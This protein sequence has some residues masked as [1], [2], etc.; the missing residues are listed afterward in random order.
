MITIPKLE[1]AVKQANNYE[2]PIRTFA[3]DP[4]I[5]VLIGKSASGKSS[6]A[7]DICEK[8]NIQQIISCTSRPPRQNEVNGIDYNFLNI[9]DFNSNDFIACET[10]KNWK[11]GVRKTDVE[12]PRNSIIVLTPSGFREFKEQWGD[13]VV[14]IYL[15]SKTLDRVQR[16]M[17]RD[18][19][20]PET[21]TEIVRRLRTDDQDFYEFE[22]EADYLVINKGE[23]NKVLN[24]VIEII[25]K[26]T[27]GL[28]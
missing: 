19:I 22:F 12:R 21:M 13:R 7:K 16:S 25:V 26:E 20:D 17:D 24:Q 2:T 4:K 5:F 27:L 18:R 28:V 8:I 14:G 6:F 9:E 1:Y 3:Y 15:M 23:Y 10:Y 11:Y